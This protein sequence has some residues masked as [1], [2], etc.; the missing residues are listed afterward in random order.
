MARRTAGEL[1]GTALELVYVA[2]NVAD[3]ENAE[4]ALT[5]WGMEYALNLEPFWM[6]NPFGFGTEYQGLY[7]Y[8]PQ[9]MAHECRRILEAHGFDPVDQAWRKAKGEFDG[10]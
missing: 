5:K 9:T 1:D 4:Q 2:S 10:A 7:F 6:T 8:V 3:A